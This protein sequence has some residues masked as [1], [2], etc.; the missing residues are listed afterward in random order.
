MSQKISAN[1]QKQLQKELLQLQ[2]N[3]EER[4]AKLK[5]EDPFS[6][7][8]HASDNAAIDTDVREKVGHETIEAEINLLTKKLEYVVRALEKIYKKTYG[9]CESCKKAIPVERLK[10]VPEARYCIECNKRLVK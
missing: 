6:D 3:L 7:P 5:A 2:K 8:D 1:L 4:I 10:L 9:I